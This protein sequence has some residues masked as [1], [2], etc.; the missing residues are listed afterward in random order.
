[1]IERIEVW[2]NRI[3]EELAGDPRRLAD[4]LREDFEKQLEQMPDGEVPFSAAEAAAP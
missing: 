4:D 1:M 3:F 2:I